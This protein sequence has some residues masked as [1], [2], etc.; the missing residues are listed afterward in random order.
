MR[1]SHS[2]C[3]VSVQHF[4]SV[5][6]LEMNM[7]LTL[8]RHLL[9]S[10]YQTFQN[11]TF[12]MI[13]KVGKILIPTANYIW[14]FLRISWGSLKCPCPGVLFLRISWVI[15]YCI[16]SIVLFGTNFGR[17]LML[18]KYVTI[19]RIFDICNW[20]HPCP[21]FLRNNVSACPV[22]LY[23]CPGSI[24]LRCIWVWVSSA[25]DLN[26]VEFTRLW[27]FDQ[28]IFVMAIVHLWTSSSFAIFF[29]VIGAT[30][31]LPR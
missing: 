3:N 14:K 11:L 26:L 21:T 7:W 19:N 13:C 9:G 2:C 30:L 20:T 12:T 8:F 24:S 6:D 17:M 25:R 15:T 27:F 4:F 16:S 22:V 5:F 31:I 1:V 28:W 10:D 18:Y 29:L 23:L